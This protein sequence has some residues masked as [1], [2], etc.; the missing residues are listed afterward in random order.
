MQLSSLN[1][2]RIQA[3]LAAACLAGAFLAYTSGA[4]PDSAPLVAPP[5]ADEAPSARIAEPIKLVTPRAA[6]APADDEVT[7]LR[8]VSSSESRRLQEDLEQRR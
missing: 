3:A 5:L 6:E 8:P 2:V 7:Q 1:L 4:E